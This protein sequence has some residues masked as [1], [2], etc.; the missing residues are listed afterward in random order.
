M[1][2]ALTLLLLAGTV[3]GCTAIKNA[4]NDVKKENIQPPTPLTV[5]TPTLNV[6][7]VWSDSVGKGA[8]TSGVRLMPAYADGKLYAA[9][10]DGTIEA[11][12]AATGRTLWSKH[13]GTRHGW[14]LHHGENSQRWSGGPAVDG[15][16]LVVGSL[17]GD[18]NA[19][20]AG[21]GAERWHV[22]VSSEV[23]APA[24]IADGVVVVRTNDGRLYGLDANDGSRKWIY[25][26]ATVPILSLRGNATPR[27]ADGV[28]YAGQD[29]GK[30]VALR[31]TDG[32]T[33]WEQT[34]SAGEG[35]TEIER[36]QD[37]D[38][39]VTVGDGV[40]YAA[41]YQGQVMA[42]IAQSGRPLWTHALSSYTGVAVAATQIYVIDADSDVWA[43]DL[44]TGASNWKQD[45][46]KYRWLSEAA[47]QGDYVVVGDIE[48]YVHWLASADGKLAAR[49][50]LSK[51]AI[52]AAPVVVGDMIYVEDIR[53]QLGAYR[54]GK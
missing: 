52:Q 42:L 48:G 1:K 36:L 28:V 16:L 25:D 24:A 41:G 30:V 53:G 17:E 46:L 11:L 5:F 54:I 8:G 50:R 44:R 9:G 31:L 29:N 23:I 26:R 45:E 3:V 21:T 51:H 39:N 38:G 47:V 35:R 19:F 34:L 13:L 6:Q 15:S 20:D 14:I 18:V 10:V 33:A 2:R 32:A 7:K 4:F 49:I 12:D 40:V 43:L 22:Q 37:V 27:I